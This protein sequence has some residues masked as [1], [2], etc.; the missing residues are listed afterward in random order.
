MVIRVILTFVSRMARFLA[1]LA[2][3]FTLL[4][5]KTLHALQCLFIFFEVI[6]PRLVNVKL[7]AECFP[8]GLAATPVHFTTVLRLMRSTGP[9][10]VLR[11]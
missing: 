2:H 5:G 8:V 7:T 1:A 10:K 11:L 3:L 6:V 9:F 4:P